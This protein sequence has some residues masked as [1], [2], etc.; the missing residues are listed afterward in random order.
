MVCSIPPSNRFLIEFGAGPKVPPP[1]ETFPK[2]GRVMQKV[3]SMMSHF[4]APRPLKKAT[5]NRQIHLETLAVGLDESP[6]VSNYLSR[7]S[8]LQ[9]QFDLTHLKHLVVHSLCKAS[10][11]GS[12]GVSNIQEIIRS[13]PSLKHIM[14][15]CPEELRDVCIYGTTEL[16]T[17]A[18]WFLHWLSTTKF[19]AT[20]ESISLILPKI[21][22]DTVAGIIDKVLSDMLAM[23]PN[24]RKVYAYTLVYHS[25]GE[26]VIRPKFGAL[27][28]TG[29][30]EVITISQ[31]GRNYIPSVDLNI[32]FD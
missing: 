31:R 6:V 5:A 24:I 2:M 11:P 20:I 18:S 21:P 29:K 13:T 26:Y 7:A 22:E 16:R 8:S 15:V 4:V 27:D 3:V 23:Q 19:P 32:W 9:S 12:Y 30:L 1:P 14:L 17:S 25:Y 10:K 28:R